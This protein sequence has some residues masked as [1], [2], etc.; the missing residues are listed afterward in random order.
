[1]LDCNTCRVMVGSLAAITRMAGTSM[2]ITRGNAFLEVQENYCSLI[3][4]M[5]GSK[6]A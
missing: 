1:M 4:L 2:L 3:A 6:L 5:Q